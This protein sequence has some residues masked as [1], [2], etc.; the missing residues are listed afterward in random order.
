MSPESNLSISARDIEIS[1]SICDLYAIDFNKLYLGGR[2]FCDAYSANKE[3]SINPL[4]NHMM[5]VTGA[6]GSGYR[7][8]YGLAD[9]LLENI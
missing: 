5:V 1:K 9:T 6:S 3:F 8:S 4:G 7:F 2:V